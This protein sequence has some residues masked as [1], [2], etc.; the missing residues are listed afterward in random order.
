MTGWAAVVLAHRWAVLLVAVTVLVLGGVWGSGVFPHLRFEGFLDETTEAAHVTEQID[1]YLGRREPDIVAVYTAPPGQSLD[2]IGPQV[3]QRLTALDSGRVE[4]VDSYWTVSVVEKPYLRSADG[5]EALAAVTLHRTDSGQRPPYRDLLSTLQVPGVDTALTGKTVIDDA[6]NAQL[7]TDLVVAES[8]S[9]PVTLMLL[10]VVFGGLIAAAVP[11]FVAA[12]SVLSALGALRLLTLLTEVNAFALNVTSLLCLGLAIDYGLFL[13]S[14]FREELRAGAATDE[15]VRRTVVTAGRTVCFSA[16]LLVCAFAGMLV[17]PQEVI[18]SLGLGAISAALSAAVLSLT[19]VPAALAIVGAR[20]DSLSWRR[21]AVGRGEVRARRFWGSVAER[22]MRHP[23]RV[24]VP[25]A[26]ALA[27]CAVPVVLTRFG[28]ISYTS[29]PHGNAVRIATEQWIQDFRSPGGDITVLVHGTSGAPPPLHTGLGFAAQAEAVD[30]VGDAQPVAAAADF[31]VISAS[32][33][34]R[35]DVER[36]NASVAALREVTPPTGTWVEVGGPF[37]LEA[38]NARSITATLPTMIAIMVGATLLLLFVAFGTV[39]LPVKAVVMAGLS[40]GAT[41]GLL[42]WIF[43]QG[44]GAGLVG[45]DPAP[46]QPTLIVLILAVVFGLSTDYEIFL[47]SRMVE[48]HATG[49]TTREAVRTGIAV[50]GRVVTCAA[51]ILGTVT[52]AFALSPM[53]IMRF[54]GVGMIIALIIDAT[55]VRMLLVPALITLM[56]NA[57][58]WAPAPLAR[59]HHRLTSG[60][61]GEPGPR[62]RA[63]AAGRGTGAA[64]G[65]HRSSGRHALDHHVT[66]GNTEQASEG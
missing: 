49:A 44:H 27:V 52:A 50:T 42:T 56:G 13:V 31:T 29:L 23:V 38:D 61:F 36:A 14:R 4:R 63:P 66:A 11:V 47:M 54:L 51:L 40:L 22:V 48:A 35:A 64:T 57:N 12:L 10:V 30:G 32:V 6:F 59:L 62:H 16:L 28:S 9:L 53:T 41:F 33:T 26:L 8:V 7:K 37:A 15:A 17:F 65:R 3:V 2:D 43:Q 5:T 20:I 18:R 55:L 25:I 1:E 60:R 46:V 21:G 58:W 39:V 24:A 34:D 45:V 19:A